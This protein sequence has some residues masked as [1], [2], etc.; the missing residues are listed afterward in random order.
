M[1]KKK[2]KK[3]KNH[4]KIEQFD[5]KVIYW[6]R[7]HSDEVARWALFVIFF[8]FGILKIFDLSPAGPL[9][10][11][12]LEVTFLSGLN[13]VGFVVGFGIFEMLMGIMIIF[14]KLE[15]ITFALMLFHLVTTIMPLFML[16]DVTWYQT[17]VPTLTGQYI[18]K[19]AALLAVGLMLFARLKPMSITHSVIGEE[20][21]D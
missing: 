12:L 17:F 19:N 9:V 15:R 4:K 18:I 2:A 14:P 11:Q 13:P 16:A 8:W 1:P 7:H 20:I 3:K 5:K 21:P 6:L 10:Q